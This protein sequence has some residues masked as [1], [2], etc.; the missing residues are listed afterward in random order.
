MVFT[1]LLYVILLSMLFGGL[2]YICG[3][4]QKGSQIFVNCITALLLYMIIVQ[5]AHSGLPAGSAFAHGIPFIN[6]IQQAGGIKLLMHNSPG[7]FAS[8]FVEFTTLILLIQWIAGL[9]S[10]PGAGLAGKI[11]SGIVIVFIGILT[12]GFVMLSVKDNIV[13]KWCVYCVECVITG[14]SILY[15]PAMIISYIS[16]LKKGNYAVT[17][18]MSAFPKTSLGKAVSSSIT[19]AVVFIAFALALESQY[20]SICNVFAGGLEILKCFGGIIVMLIGIYYLL[21][22]LKTAGRK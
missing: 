21:T 17:Y 13:L 11:T 6:H 16:G 9:V 2:G 20:G 12:Y 4:K 7:I 19:S 15:T 22:G 10:F 8:D 5:L 18:L 1:L 14:G 3:E